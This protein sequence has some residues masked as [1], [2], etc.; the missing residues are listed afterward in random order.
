MMGARNVS[1]FAGLVLLI[2]AVAGGNLASAGSSTNTAAA[3][4]PTNKAQP[5]PPATLGG[6]GVTF[7][8][9][10]APIVFHNCA[11]CH[12]P[13]EAG[14]FPLLSYDDVKKHARQIVA[15]TQS[16]FM[17]P[18]PPEPQPLKFADE[19]RLS[20]RQIAL[21]KKWV[22]QGMT[23]G[24][25]ADLPPQPK[26]VPGWQLGEP[27][28]IVKAAK[29]FTLPPS[30]IDT[31][32]NFILPVPI[33]DDRWVKG[34]EIRPGD[35]RLIH[36]ANV[37]VDRL[38]LSRSLEKAPGAGYGGMEVKV[39]SQLFGPNSSHFLFWKPG[40]VPY[41]EPDDMALRMDKGTDLVLKTHL[42]PSGK[43]ETIQP[44]I[45][46]YFTNKPATKHPMLFQ[47]TCDPLLDIPPGD[48]NFV[49]T[50]EFTLPVDVSLLA[51]YPHAHYLGKDL[52]ATATLPDGTKK[53]L[54][55]IPH[56]DLN[57]QAVYRYAQPVPLPKGTILSMRYVYDNSDGNLANTNHPPKRVRAG[58][59]ASDEMAQLGFQ[60]LPKSIPHST[61]DPRMVLQEALTP[62]PEKDWSELW[63]ECAQNGNCEGV[64]QMSLHS[65][66]RPAGK[67]PTSSPG[68]HC[69]VRP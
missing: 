10:I 45:G 19:R 38:E 31:Y 23:E 33:T 22:D 42:Q 14:P 1:I 2:A 41:F 36:H 26:F 13:G 25:P 39:E 64:Q 59:R 11:P 37:V 3:K 55:H 28:L 29:P 34:V 61:V 43:P 4:V 47:L 21:I 24:R 40:T 20:D 53:T 58:N 56:W 46:I 44:S 69:S 54:I 52:K 32:W 50:D 8:R 60:V 35:K 67:H 18:W 7:N 30:G 62:P 5:T 27:D 17:P 48:E 16:R 49:V 15:V 6:Q 9:D 68:S 57:W 12:R 63:A 65:K 51:I 66:D